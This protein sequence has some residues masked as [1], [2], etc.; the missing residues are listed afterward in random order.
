[1]YDVELPNMLYN[2][3]VRLLQYEGKAVNVETRAEMTNWT[4]ISTFFLTPSK[5]MGRSK[6]GKVNEL[7]LNLAY[8][9]LWL[10]FTFVIQVVVELQGDLVGANGPQDF[11]VK[12]LLIPSLK[13]WKLDE[14]PEPPAAYTVR[15]S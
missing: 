10:L 12:K 4:T 9:L 15:Q 5:T 7:I 8:N 13:V 14:N 3:T 1:M 11:S 2:I 6:D